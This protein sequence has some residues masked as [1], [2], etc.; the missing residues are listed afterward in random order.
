MSSNRKKPGV[1]FWTIVITVLL[2]LAYP[3]SFGPACWMADRE[4]VATSVVRDVYDPLWA[5]I[6][7]CPRPIQRMMYHYG[8]AGAP[9]NVLPFCCAQ[10]VY[11]RAWARYSAE[12]SE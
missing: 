9:V 7:S 5:V 10:D 8:R 2:L 3:I 4:I 12:E 1:A 6:L 11:A